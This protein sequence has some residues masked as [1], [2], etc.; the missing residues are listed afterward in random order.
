MLNIK[1][2]NAKFGRYPCCDL[3]NNALRYL[4]EEDIDKAISEIVFAISKADGYLHEDIVY[5]IENKIK[6]Y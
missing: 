6:Y 3:L 4:L 2:K 1:K 5:R